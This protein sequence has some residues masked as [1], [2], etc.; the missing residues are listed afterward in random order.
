MKS[1]RIIIF[2][3]AALVCFSCQNTPEVQ[4]SVRACAPMPEGR[5]AACATTLNGKAYVFAGRDSE[6]KRRNELFRFRDLLFLDDPRETS[7]LRVRQL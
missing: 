5:A 7:N 1:E 4:V 2:L 6:G 3:I